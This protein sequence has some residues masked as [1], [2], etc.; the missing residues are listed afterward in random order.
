M[1]EKLTYQ[2]ALELIR[3]FK[4]TSA[5][6]YMRFRNSCPDMKTQL[7]SQPMVF[8]KEDWN[9]WDEFTG[10]EYLTSEHDIESLQKLALSLSLKT[11]EEWQ[12]AINTKQID[13]PVH[14]NK[15]KGFKNWNEF[16]NKPTYIDFPSLLAFTRS[17]KLK[18]QM[19]WREWCKVNTRP[20]DVPFNLR[21]NYFDDYLR[22]CPTK[23]PSFWRYIFQ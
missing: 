6:D 23:K 11:K 22:E 4:I 12:L 16:F 5:N 13:A 7:P 3:D 9:G 14:I 17:L 19:D 18:T 2:Q 20:K 21:K 8:Y 10:V 1:N 15:I